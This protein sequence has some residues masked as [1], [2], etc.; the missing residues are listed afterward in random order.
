[1]EPD[2]LPLFVD[3][4]FAVWTGDWLLI[5][6]ESLRG[7]TVGKKNFRRTSEE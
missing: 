6:V 4:G 7:C 5:R 3:R 2:R 1:L